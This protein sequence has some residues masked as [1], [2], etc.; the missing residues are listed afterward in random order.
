VHS[1]ETGLEVR[2]A[3]PDEYGP[4]AELIAA[5]N[6]RPETQCLHA[7]D[8][9][10]VAAARLAEMAAGGNGRV[11]VA[12]RSGSV[13]GALAADVDEGVGRAWLWGP[14]AAGGRDGG[15]PAGDEFGRR[16]ALMLTRVEAALPES[17][18]RLDA[19]TNERNERSRRFF[20][21]HGF[22]ERGRHHV[23]VA[24]RA[25]APSPEGVVEA[26]ASLA[27]SAAALHDAEFPNTYLRW[28]DLVATSGRTRR[29]FVAPAGGNDRPQVGPGPGVAGYIFAER[30][31]EDGEGHIYYVAV[32]PQA[33]GRGLGRRLL[34]AALHWLFEVEGAPRVHLTVTEDRAGAQRLY[35]RAGFRRAVTG[36]ALHRD[37][38]H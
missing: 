18:R 1:Q 22:I 3:R 27:A 34:A 9:A 35:E 32:A 24:E 20:R 26:G 4:V 5:A 29:L 13:L 2:S 25:A 6:A 17:V 28:G 16:S 36:V 11:I 8:R 33:R 30:S 19:F 23:Y 31:E 14:F 7:D 38:G 15:L 37:R 12:A 10:E 21:A